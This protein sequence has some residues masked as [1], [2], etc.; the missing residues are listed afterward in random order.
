MA[1]RQLDVPRGDLRLPVVD[2]GPRSGPAVLCLHGFP[3]DA[4]AFDEVRRLLVAHGMRVLVPHQRGYSAGARPRGRSPYAMSELVGDALAVL[5]SAG[6][7]V[8]HVAGHDWGGAVAWALAA[9]HPDRVSG[10]TALSTP[11]PRAMAGALFRGQALR[12]S[13]IG[14]FQ[15]PVIPE[16]LA[17][18]PGA[19]LVRLA[20]SRSG[21]PAAAAD[22]YL[23]RLAEPRALSSALGWYRAMPMNSGY[24]VGRVRVPTTYLWG[25]K[26]PFFA[27][28][29]VLSTGDWVEAPFRSIGL[30]TGHWLPENQ[31]DQV[32]DAV[33]REVV[34]A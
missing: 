12:S 15:L 28:S 11:H 30:P 27:R 26:D 5:D 29:A 19:P 24:Q 3:Q 23:H 1:A 16:V 20:L 7:A 8:A 14:L 4:T 34:A 10:L 21:L 2:D 13:Y 17:L 31:S 6:V 33:R 32:A 9:N 25:T 22:R 18:G